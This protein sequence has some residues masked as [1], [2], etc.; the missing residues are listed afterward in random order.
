M[1]RY[2][3]NNVKPSKIALSTRWIQ[4]DHI[5]H[6]NIKE[7][8]YLQQNPENSKQGSVDRFSVCYSERAHTVPQPCNNPH[9]FRDPHQKPHVGNSNNSIN[10]PEGQGRGKSKTKGIS[11]LDIADIL[12]YSKVFPNIHKY[13]YIF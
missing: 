9:G 7:N 13:F 5:Q 3:T 6:R 8:D 1:N 4:R 10:I 12:K 11:I 2:K